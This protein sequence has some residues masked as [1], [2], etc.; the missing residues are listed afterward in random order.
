MSQSKL[1]EALLEVLGYVTR[2]GDATS[3]LVNVAILFGDNANES[4]SGRSYR[5]KSKSKAW[6]WLGASINFVFDDEHCERAY[7]ND[8]ARAAK[9]LSESK[10]K[11]KPA[12]K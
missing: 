3:Q 5:L 4:V 11:K 7:S 6:A 12:K 2:V 1:D 10:P 8:V 9:T